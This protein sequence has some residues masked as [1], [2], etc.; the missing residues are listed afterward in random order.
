MFALSWIRL[1]KVSKIVA[2]TPQ[3]WMLHPLTYY[4]RFVYV[5]S[6]WGEW[7]LEHANCNHQSASTEIFQPKRTSDFVSWRQFPRRGS[8]NLTEWLQVWASRTTHKFG[9]RCCVVFGWECFH[10]YL[11]GQDMVKMEWDQKPLELAIP[12]KKLIHQAPLCLQKMILR[13]KLYSMWQTL[14]RQLFIADKLVYQ[15]SAREGLLWWR[16]DTQNVS[17]CLFHGIYYSN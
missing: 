17:Y 7:K 15:L 5:H 6:Y 10:D 13:V 12:L 9:R 2:W 16:A 14:G 8:S 3:K 4:P 11:Y 1:W